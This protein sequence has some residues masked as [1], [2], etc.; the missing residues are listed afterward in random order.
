MT[1]E[2]RPAAI[3]ASAPAS[4]WAS[5]FGGAA[6][7]AV[8]PANR[9]NRELP[10][11][12]VEEVAA[13]AGEPQDDVLGARRPADRAG[14]R[15]PRLPAAGAGDR[16]AAHHRAGGAAQ[17]HLDRAAGGRRSDAGGERR[18]ARAEG[19]VA[20]LDGVAVLDPPDVNAAFG[21]RLGLDHRL[22]IN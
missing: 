4:H 16:A 11:V 10:P 1:P 19:D 14:H 21:N 2:T 22:P 9:S 18:R 12:H 17:T 5:R 8:D 20:D 3:V 13:A 15:G 7:S 6:S